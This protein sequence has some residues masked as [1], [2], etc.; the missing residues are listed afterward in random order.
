MNGLVERTGEVALEI[1]ASVPRKACSI[2]NSY[3]ALDAPLAP[4]NIINAN[5]NETLKLF[6]TKG[7]LLSLQ[8][9]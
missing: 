6:L 7:V 2:L 1:S 9:R 5:K 3:L 4:E 8:T